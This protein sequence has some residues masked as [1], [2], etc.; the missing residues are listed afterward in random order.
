MD[1]S[2]HSRPERRASGKMS[3][4][5]NQPCE[6]GVDVRGLSRT[7]VEKRVLEA[8]AH[9]DLSDEQVRRLLGFETQF[10][11][12]AFLKERGVHL[13][14]SR[15]DLEQDLKF[16]DSWLSSQTPPR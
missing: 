1:R 9:G 11:V 3:S 8:Y 16:S 12:H 6:L 10:E 15:E 2:L 4:A 13:N 7:E 5:A 14:Y